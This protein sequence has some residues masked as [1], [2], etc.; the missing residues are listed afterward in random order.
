[1][2]KLIWLWKKFWGRTYYI[3][4]TDKLKDNEILVHGHRIY[5]KDKGD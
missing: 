2:N 3:I 1:M 5:I 4:Y